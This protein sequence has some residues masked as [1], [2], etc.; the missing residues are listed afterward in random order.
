[1][2]KILHICINKHLDYTFCQKLRC[3]D[4]LLYF[5]DKNIHYCIMSKMAYCVI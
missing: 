4:R 3:F 1:M 2:Q 5:V